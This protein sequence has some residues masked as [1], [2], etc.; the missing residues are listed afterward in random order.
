MR[1]V[2]LFLAACAAVVSAIGLYAQQADSI[3]STNNPLEVSQSVPRLIMFSG[4]VKD[5]TGKP[6]TGPVDLNFAIYKEQADAA[7][8]WQ[9]SQ[10]LNVDEQGHY[11]AIVGA[12]QPEGLPVDL[13]TSGEARWLGVSAGK[14]AEQPRVLLVSVPYA[15]K[16]NDAEMLGGKPAS[17]YALAPAAE[18]STPTGA[19]SAGSKGLGGA[20]SSELAAPGTPKSGAKPNVA[21]TGTQNYIPVWTNS[22]GTLGNS[23]IYQSGSNIGIGTTAPVS[24]LDVYGASAGLRL[25]GT[26]TH[27]VWITG[28]TSGRLGQDA[29]GFFL[30]SDTN[31]AALR[32]A[33]NNGSGHEWMR[34]T[35]AGNVGIGTTTPG[36]R[37]DVVGGSARVTNPSGTTQLQVSGSATSGRLGQDSG[38]LFLSSDTSGGALRFA[39]NNGSGHE[40]LRIT[41][42]GR[43]GIGT[44][45]P[46]HALDVVGD[47]SASTNLNAG[48]NLSVTGTLTGNG[49]GLTALNASN[50]AS[51]AVPGAVL[52]GTYSNALTFSNASNSFTGNGAGLTN[53]AATTATTA[54]GL[55]CTGCVGST[56]LG[57]NYATSA[58]KG[59]PA[60]NALLLN[61]L[62]S[63]AF[64]PAGSYATI[65]ANSFTASQSISGDLTLTGTVNGLLIAPNLI[66]G[67]SQSAN[68]LGGYTGMG[69]KSGGPSRVVG[70]MVV[71]ETVAGG[72]TITDGVIGG[73]IAGGGGIKEGNPWPNS[74][75]NNWGTVGGGAYN[76]AGDG[77]GPASSNCC[78]VVA[79]GLDN[80]ATIYG[81]TVSGGYSNSATSYHATVPGGVGN[82][83]NGWFSFAAGCL[84]TAAND[85]A[86]VWSGST[87]AGT[88]KC[89]SLTSS[90][91]GQ[92]VALAPGGVIFY[93]NTAL[94]AGVSLAAGGG[95]WGSVSDRNVKANFKPVIAE[96]LLARLNAMPMTTWNYKAQDSRFR[97]L[98]PM[99]QDFYGA[100]GLGE[101]DKH[102]DD[103]DGQGVALAGVQ[104]LYR[105]SLEKD[106][107]IQKQQAQIR[108][109]TLQVQK[110]EKVQRQMA[111]LEARLAQIETW[112][113]KP[114]P[115]SV[116][117]AA[118]A[119]PAPR[120]MTLAKA[121]F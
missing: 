5:L 13:F 23:A 2:P 80:K 32:F 3:P 74:V 46:A 68:M 44:A 115:R 79:G 57:V 102:I 73:T 111:R 36:Y 98:G 11:T 70:G 65:G 42:A 50:L 39:T 26:G 53:V 7:P 43:V 95:S 89:T 96:N 1:R 84:A 76:R 27:Q 118:A 33:T 87:G 78:E 110:L 34:I 119:K 4:T 113:A 75:T 72:N 88:G 121:Q 64:Q 105:L 108:T 6:L 93:S 21:G 38:G 54:S 94:S 55:S 29:A 114:Q 85:G 22:T 116:K 112:T 117:R 10:T 24:A 47:I 40:W 103:I 66:F 14:L 104:A 48:G 107:E 58:S 51:G 91:S 63:T 49:S 35:S 9:E 25:R 18:G 60:S 82:T 83:A 28:A 16:A 86:F 120:S 100:F 109:L 59:G 52:S 71:A 41:S 17:A 101:D 69:G 45:T 12:M 106:A 15:L 30:T 19:P 81:A 97:H 92:F 67:T 62:A 8:L 77:T 56:Q 20:A 61:G 31:G 37:L 99:A 90:A